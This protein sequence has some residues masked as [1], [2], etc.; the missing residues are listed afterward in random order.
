MLFRESFEQ[1]NAHAD[2]PSSANRLKRKQ[3]SEPCLHLFQ[4]T[5][6][7]PAYKPRAPLL[8]RSAPYL[9]RLHDTGDFVT[10]GI[11]T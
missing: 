5:C 4:H 7:S 10:S 2:R 11:G 1:G 9:V 8:P 6:R 3:R